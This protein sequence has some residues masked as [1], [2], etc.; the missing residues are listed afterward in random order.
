VILICL[1]AADTSCE[2]IEADGDGM[3]GGVKVP[4][5]GCKDHFAE[6]ALWCYVKGG[7]ACADAT[8]SGAYPG[9]AYRNCEDGNIA[10]S[11]ACVL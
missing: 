6:G 9:A 3:S 11:L 4:N 1:A 5:M 8:S 7:V 10:L 2:C